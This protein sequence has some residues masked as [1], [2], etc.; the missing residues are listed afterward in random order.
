[1]ICIS[2]ILFFLKQ[3]E[4]INEVDAVNV[5]R[6]LMQQKPKIIIAILIGLEASAW[7][8]LIKDGDPH[9]TNWRNRR[10]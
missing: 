8:H 9:P 2:L 4:F 10:H 7:L 5:I 3:L 6:Q 1:M